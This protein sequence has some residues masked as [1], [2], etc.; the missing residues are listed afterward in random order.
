MEC[1]G[2]SFENGR[3]F[4]ASLF[5]G[6]AGVVHTPQPF[7]STLTAAFDSANSLRL[8]RRRLDSFSVKWLYPW[9][10]GFSAV[11]PSLGG[12]SLLHST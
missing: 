7:Y 11:V 5:S 3:G 9:F 8:S 2:V 4:K 6:K 1:S 10:S 12:K